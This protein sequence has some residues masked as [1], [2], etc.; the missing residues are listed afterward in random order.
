MVP[1]INERGV[2]VVCL[3]FVCHVE[4]FAVFRTAHAHR[5]LLDL[6]DQPKRSV[7]SRLPKIDHHVPALVDVEGV[8]DVR[9]GLIRE[10]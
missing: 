1:D 4:Q 3:N 5:A 8:S 6:L 10:A 9:T 7:L 2:R